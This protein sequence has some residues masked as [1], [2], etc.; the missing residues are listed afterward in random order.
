MVDEAIT[1]EVTETT[2][3][4]QPEEAIR[5]LMNYAFDV[6]ET[7]V[8]IVEQVDEN[9][10]TQHQENIPDNPT[11]PSAPQIDYNSFVKETF[12]KDTVE[13]VKAEW[14]ELQALKSKPQTAEEIKF[15]NEKSKRVYENLLAGNTKL[16]KK[17]LDAQEL[18]EGVE[19]MGD[20]QKLKLYIKLQNPLFSDKLVEEE[21]EEL[22]N[23]D[24]T[25]IE[26]HKLER[27][28]IKLQQRKIND[29]V[30]A[31]EYFAQYSSKFELPE[32]NKAPQQTI[33]DESYEAYKASMTS[34][35]EAYNNITVP[36]VNALK[37]TDIP[38]K[39]NINDAN[40]QM[41]FD[42]SIEPTKEDFIK[43]KEGALGI[44]NYITGKCYDKDGNLDATK[45][46]RIVL[47]NDNFDKYVQSAARQAVNAER[48]R[49]ATQDAKGGASGARDY[50]VNGEK[51]ELQKRMEFA[52]Q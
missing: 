18:L 51:T 49:V 32:I 4:I 45:L 52:F 8:D 23:L 31:A 44:M 50:N 1:P 16:V 34:A 29:T 25:A 19:T 43:A 22:Y 20:E 17:H 33:V 41:Q 46:A 2:V 39:V 24:E 10:N 5:N 21:Y 30:K 27:E 48:K 38:L 15:A 28:K 40:N 12:G 11:E 13:D 47:L 37:E 35:D 7:P 6:P 36:K 3:D 14:M 9:I 26:D 42:V